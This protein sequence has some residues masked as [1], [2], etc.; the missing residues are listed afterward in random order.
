MPEP[1][2]KTFHPP[3]AYFLLTSAEA[4]LVDDSPLVYGSINHVVNYDISEDAQQDDLLISIS[5]DSVYDV[6]NR[7]TLTLK[8]LLGATIDRNIITINRIDVQ[9]TIHCYLLT[10]ATMENI[11]SKNEE[12]NNKWTPKLQA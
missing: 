11:A 2:P 8:D 10:P 12:R 4:F 5:W 9:H 7:L 1:T 6:H 3:A